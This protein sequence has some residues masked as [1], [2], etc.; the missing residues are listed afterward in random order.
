MNAAFV[1]HGRSLAEEID[2][3]EVPGIP[4]LAF[5]RTRRMPK[6]LK[7]A[8]QPSEDQVQRS[9]LGYLKRLPAEP[10]FWH[11]RNERDKK[12]TRNQMFRRK[13]LGL[14]SGVPDLTICW[15]N[16]V[17]VFLEVKAPGGE[18]SE[19]Q[20]DRIERLQQ[21][22]HHVGVAASLD[23]ALAVFRRAGVVR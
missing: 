15:P 9:I 10:L 16:G 22:G 23:D 13:G 21:L 11:V 18:T 8:P 2:G 19:A 12:L 3:L 4:S 5:R 1:D 17:V 20:E 14:K 7:G 6:G